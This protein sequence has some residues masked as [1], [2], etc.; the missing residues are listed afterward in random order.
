MELK[1]LPVGGYWYVAGVAIVL[2]VL[3]LGISPRHIAMPTGRRVMLKVLRLLSIVMLVL[4]LLR[5]TLVLT[6]STPEEAT[7][8]LLID[9]TRSMTVGDSLDNRTRYEGVKLLLDQAADEFRRLRQNWRVEAYTFADTLEPLKLGEDGKFNLP[10]NPDGEQTPIGYSLQE[11]LES[12]ADER[13]RGVLL[14]SDGAQRA[15]PPRDAAAQLV[16]RLY[17]AEQIPLYTFA[18]GQA[19]SRDR[20]DLAIEDLLVNSTLFANAPAEV[21]GQLRADGYANRNVKVQLLWED[22][23]GKMSVVNTRQQTITTDPSRIPLVLQHTPTTPGEFKLTL[24]AE[25]PEGELV[26]TNNEESTFVT[27]REGGIKVLYL[28]GSSRIGGGPSREQK[29][30]RQALA[31]SPDMLVTYRLLDYAPMQIGMA[32]DFVP[33]K[34]DVVMLDNVD[35]KALNARSWQALADAVRQGTG[36]YMGG[37]FHSFGPGGFLTTPLHTTLPIEIGPAENQNFDEP[38]REDMH[39]AGP[40][41]M[42]P[43][44]LGA[45]HPM[46]RLGSEG[47][48][49]EQ[50]RNLPALDGA[51]RFT[52]L[53]PNAQVLLQTS[54]A[55]PHPLLVVGQSGAGRTVAFAGDSTWRWQ[56]EGQGEALRRFWRQVV[57]YLAQKDGKQEGE[58]WVE[59][60]SRRVNRGGSLDIKVG[61]EPPSGKEQAAVELNV[62]VK[63]PDG[64]PHSLT[65][66]P[67]AEH[68]WLTTFAIT[69]QP[70]DY[71]VEVTARLDGATLGSARARFLVPRQDLELDRPGADPALLA[72]LARITEGAGGQALAPEELPSLVKKL[73]A[74]PPKIKTEVTQRRTF[75]DTWQFLL[76]FVAVVTTEWFLRKRWGLV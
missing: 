42:E 28:S 4:A 12:L 24:R 3:A 38:I 21:R 68:Q 34:Y 23:E 17:A 37:G 20:S 48:L 46:L 75:W 6:R 66:S 25:T 13:L 57:L 16:A 53:K 41:M 43:T 2:A 39:I 7:L 65:P 27:V 55:Q 22:A 45:Q 5:P 30:V 50:W 18:F 35:S 59:L 33:G 9:R 58:V 32:D 40:L 26:T 56:L 63:T 62:A 1:F 73:A 69:D 70:G 31:A 47:A 44:P 8:I 60:D 61:I 29:F 14:L 19:G 11:V 74:T 49:A 64:T 67:L 71:L 72:Q 10:P 51:N 36:L 54:G 76:V 15:V 52:R